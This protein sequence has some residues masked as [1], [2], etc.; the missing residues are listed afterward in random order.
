[1]IDV[2]TIW[3]VLIAMVFCLFKDG[4]HVLFA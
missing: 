1:M 4:L 3:C 2:F